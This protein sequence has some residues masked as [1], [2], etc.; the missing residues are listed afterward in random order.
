MLFD[1][2]TIM[3]LVEDCGEFAVY[4]KVTLESNVYFS[5]VAHMDYGAEI[6]GRE[7]GGEQR[8]AH[9]AED[10]QKRSQSLRDEPVHRGGRDGGIRHGG[11]LSS[12]RG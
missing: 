7:V 8:R 6:P 3:M 4:E 5:R 2:E 11:L 9:A 12:P 1:D 10:E